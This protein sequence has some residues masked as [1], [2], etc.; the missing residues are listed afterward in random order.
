VTL[1]HRAIEARRRDAVLADPLAVEL[2]ELIDFPFCRR[3]GDGERL[4]LP[5][6]TDCLRSCRPLRVVRTSN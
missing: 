2:V 5:S 4:S 1:W 6:V 3:F